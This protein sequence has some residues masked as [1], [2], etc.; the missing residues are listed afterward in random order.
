MPE[1]VEVE[2]AP[3]ARAQ[4]GEVGGVLVMLVA[5]D[6][7]VGGVAGG[8]RWLGP[9]AGLAAVAGENRA[10]GDLVGDGGLA[11]GGADRDGREPLEAVVVEVDVGAAQER[12]R[13]GLQ[14]SSIVAAGA[15]TR[16]ATVR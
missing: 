1:G 4:E 13:R 9:R 8:G 3:L 15:S 14:A 10:G 11:P 16:R 12:R 6:G 7:A 2:L 5:V